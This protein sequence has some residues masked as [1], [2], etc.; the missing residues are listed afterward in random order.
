MIGIGLT[1]W[2]GNG[3]VAAGIGARVAHSCE[4]IL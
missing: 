2:S 4:L 1:H 3:R